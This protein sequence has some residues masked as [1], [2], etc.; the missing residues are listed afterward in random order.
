M[1]PRE[2]LKIIRQIKIRTNR[3]VTETVEGLLHPIFKGRGK[4]LKRN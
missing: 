4:K 3:I 1:I 2:I